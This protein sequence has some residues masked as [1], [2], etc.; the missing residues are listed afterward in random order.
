MCSV[1]FQ[2]LEVRY[3]VHSWFW[4]IKFVIYNSVDIKKEV[5]FLILISA[6]VSV[7]ETGLFY[8]RL[9]WFFYAE[10]EDSRLNNSHSF[11]C[12]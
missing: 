8:R 4:R 1:N 2:E 10:L 7:T 3:Q 6:L 11:F 9:W 12:V 5:R